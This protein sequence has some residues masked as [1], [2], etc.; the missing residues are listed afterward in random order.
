M[1]AP[2]RNSVYQVWVRLSIDFV[3]ETVIRVGWTACAVNTGAGPGGLVSGGVVCV[4]LLLGAERRPLEATVTTV[5]VVV[6]PGQ[7]FESE[8]VVCGGSTRRHPSPFLTTQ[9]HQLVE[10]PFAGS[11]ASEMVVSELAVIRRFVGALDP[12]ASLGGRGFAGVAETATR[13]EAR[14]AKTVR[15]TIGDS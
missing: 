12:P 8:S 7:S 14:A 2:S 5:Y 10:P 4:T 11:Q 3:H 9:Y 1:G 13:A 6:R 15:R